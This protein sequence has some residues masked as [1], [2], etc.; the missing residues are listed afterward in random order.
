M[1]ELN[2]SVVR[3][4]I[5]IPA[6]TFLVG[7][8]LA[9]SGGPSVIVTTSP[10]FELSWLVEPAQSFEISHPFHSDSPAGRFLKSV[11]TVKR[12]SGRIDVEFRDPYQGGG[13]FGG[14]TA[15][16]LGAWM[17]SRWLAG[18]PVAES[19]LE[20]CSE[21]R[22]HREQVC[23]QWTSGRLG[24]GRFLDVLDAYS[25]FAPNA[26]GADLV[27]QM[28][29]GIAVWNRNK[30][31]MQKF[32]WSFD[33]LYLSLVRTGRKLKTHEYLKGLTPLEAS[34][35]REMAV[36]VEEAVAAFAF[37]DSN[38]LTAA[39]RGA[40]KVLESQGLVADHTLSALHDLAEM[41]GVRAAKG[42]GAM[43]ADVIAILHDASAFSTIEALCVRHGFQRVDT[44]HWASS[45]R[46]ES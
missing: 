4:T 11:E 17:L 19:D 9:L 41:A 3:R 10:V 46:I 6:K 22:D 12:P 43:G 30:E 39:V 38:R 36:W 40:G 45:V 20:W 21:L 34:A 16:F 18:D 29:G 1:T 8:Y 42:C 31:M 26:S 37:V 35:Q 32:S 7:E 27:S 25:E 13:G 33:D 5:L 28:T 44:S 14:S 23:P 24:G 2:G 15:E